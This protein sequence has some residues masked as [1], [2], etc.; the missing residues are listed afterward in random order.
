MEFGTQNPQKYVQANFMHSG[1]YYGGII[2]LII[3]IIYL[4]KNKS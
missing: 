2:G 1:S 4:F 3:G